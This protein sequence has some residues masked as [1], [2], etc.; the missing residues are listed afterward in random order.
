MT[1]VAGVMAVVL[2]ALAVV[3]VLWA[4]GYWWPIRDEG[5]LVAAVVGTRN[6]T[7]MPGPIPCA[8]VA[9]GLMA[10]AWW[11]WFAPGGLRRAG[12]VV[13]AAVFLIR[14]I[15][16]LRPGWRRLT[17]QEPF[18]TYDTRYYGPLCL[19]LGLG[20]AGLALVGD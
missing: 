2:L 6:A 10:A 14:G 15:L 9:V 20:F 3:H 7:R 1:F 18:R 17:S 16:P 13:L 19:A 5:R 4:I 11:P 8:L 12:L